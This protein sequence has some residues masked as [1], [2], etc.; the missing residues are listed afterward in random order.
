M[1]T[2]DGTLIILIALYHVDNYKDWDIKKD[3]LSMKIGLQADVFK[4]LSFH[5]R[6]FLKII[7]QVKHVKYWEKN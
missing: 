3:K 2:K 4:T 6:N 5:Y 7:N 1:Y